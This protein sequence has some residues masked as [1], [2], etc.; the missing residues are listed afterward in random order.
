MPNPAPNPAPGAR[1]DVPNWIE[2][3]AA[4]EA[5]PAMKPPDGRTAGR[6]RRSATQSQVSE[7]HFCLE[8]HGGSVRMN[9]PSEA[10]QLIF[11]SRL[12]AATPLVLRL[13]SL[14][15]RGFWQRVLKPEWKAGASLDRDLFEISISRRSNP[16]TREVAQFRY[17]MRVLTSRGMQIK[18]SNP[19]QRGAECD[20]NPSDTLTVD[21]PPLEGHGSGIGPKT[22][23]GGLHFTFIPY[24][25]NFS[26]PLS[27]ASLEKPILLP[28]F[29]V[30][31]DDGVG[32]LVMERTSSSSFS[33]PRTDT[34]NLI[35]KSAA[36]LMPPMAV[37]EN[38]GSM[39]TSPHVRNERSMSNSK[40]ASAPMK[41][42]DL[43]PIDGELDGS[44]DDLFSKTGFV[45]PSAEGHI[46]A[47]A[48]SRAG[49]HSAAR[50][51][52]RK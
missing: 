38:D 12:D 23:M 13:G 17:R 35:E 22:L 10:R 9:L 6:W 46:P 32:G 36:A 31:V 15:Q 21:L 34:S 29:D 51:S 41:T 45:T 43:G 30:Q 8:V 52:F 5:E 1:A 27:G 18:Y 40:F 19:L 2:E 14:Y 3:D 48:E 42:I 26:T 11:D 25:T 39:D 7:G 33:R 37:P 28:E 49:Q 4:F 16:Q 47:L 24:S 50:S 44:V 20:L